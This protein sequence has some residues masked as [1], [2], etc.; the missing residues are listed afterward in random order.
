MI[1]KHRQSASRNGG[2]LHRIGKGGV[3]SVLRFMVFAGVLSGLIAGQASAGPVGVMDLTGVPLFA[4]GGEVTAYFA[5]TDA[6]FD[7]TISLS[8]PCCSGEFFPNHATPVGTS[9]SLGSFAAGTPLTFRLHV[10]TTGFDFFTGPAAG[11]PDGIVHAGVTSW[12]SDATIPTDGLLVGFEDLFGGG[13]FDYDD[14]MFV[15][16]SVSTS[17]P[18]PT[19]LLLIGSGLVGLVGLGGRKTLKG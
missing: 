10:L 9:F 19:S 12:A 7:S 14:H 17:V 1:F 16:S 15:F 8:L 2:M 18:E 5:G 4:S 6:G 3:R 13:D 11:N